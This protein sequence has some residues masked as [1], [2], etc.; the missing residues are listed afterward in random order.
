MAT[1]SRTSLLFFF[2]YLFLSTF[3]IQTNGLYFYMNEGDVKCFLEE[4]PKDT[5]ILAKWKAS[6]ADNQARFTPQMR[7]S[8][9]FQVSALDPDNEY[10]INKNV[11]LEGRIAFSSH[12]GGEYQI[13]WQTNT[14]RWFG[15]ATKLKFE[16]EIDTGSDAIDYEEVAQAEHL[17]DLQIEVR[18]RNDQAFEIMKEQSYLKAR[19]MIA[20][21]ESESINSKVMWWSIAETV[22][23]VVSGFWQIRYLKNF[24]RQKKLV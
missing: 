16:I 17:T 2:C 9:G 3:L 1:E 8:F 21:D 22:V 19:E 20:R 13:C 4:V 15:S 5:V 12:V 11:G 18:R 6:F 14:S 24:F 10:V 23:L 7:K